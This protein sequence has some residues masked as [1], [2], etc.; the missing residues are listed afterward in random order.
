VGQKA[1]TG[2]V[3]GIVELPLACLRIKLS[4]QEMGV[5]LRRQESAQMVVEPPG[6]RWRGR[7]LKVDNRVFIAAEFSFVEQRAGAVHQT[8]EFVFRGGRD[9]FAMEARKQRGRTCAVKTFVVIK[10][11]YLHLGTVTPGNTFLLG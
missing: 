2:D 6:D 8:A 7:I 1:G 9:A 3:F 5:V 11:A 4:R 10:N